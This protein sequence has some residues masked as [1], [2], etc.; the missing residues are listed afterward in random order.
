MYPLH[1]LF[2]IGHKLTGIGMYFNQAKLIRQ[3]HPFAREDIQ[4]L[5]LSWV[6]HLK[7]ISSTFAHAVIEI[8]EILGEMGKEF[9]NA[10]PQSPEEFI[11]WA[12]ENHQWLMMQ[13][14]EERASRAIYLYGFALGEMMSTLSL[15][16]CVLDITAQYEIPMEDQLNNN[17]TV[18]LELLKRWETLARACAQI[19]ELSFLCSQF[20]L[21]SSPIESIF[22][23]S[24]AS[25]TPLEKSASAREI[26]ARID[27]L[28]AIETTCR[29]KLKELD[30]LFPI[31]TSAPA[32]TDQ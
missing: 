18:V 2:S 11:V 14:P 29:D 12:N 30:T 19:S 6:E 24:F 23:D 3:L 27:V 22:M 8:N 1:V 13:L 4:E 21:I 20:L 28:G 16:A 10:P 25:K 5:Q 17:R 7:K 26:R 31:E 9:T 15:S 32:P